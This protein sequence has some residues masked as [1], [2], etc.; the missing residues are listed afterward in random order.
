MRTALAR[1]LALLLAAAVLPASAAPPSARALVRRCVDAHG[2]A[3]ALRRAAAIVQQGTVT[4]LLHPGV[5]GRIGRAYQRPGRLRV[6]TSWPDGPGEIRVLDG[7]AGWRNGAPVGGPPLTAMILQ[8]ARLD[9]PALLSAWEARVKERGTW[10]HEGKTLRV[11]ALEVAPGMEVEAG[12][13]PGSG[14]VLRSRTVGPGRDGGT[15]EFVTTYSDFREVGGVLLAFREGN[16]ANGS[17]TGETV[18]ERV[19]VVKGFPPETF[20]P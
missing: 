16:W 13:D 5:K 14:R 15:V 3:E 6:E 11:L 9:V 8:A 12:V 7:G 17:T 10:S 19:E 2:G 18:L 20:R 1:P 4:S